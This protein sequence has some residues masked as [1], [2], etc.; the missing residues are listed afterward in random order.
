MTGKYGLVKL[1]RRYGNICLPE[2]IV[3]DVRELRRK[4]LMKTPLSPRLLSEMQA[5]FGRKEQVILFQ[6]RRGY[7]PVLECRQC[8]WVPRCRSC[9]VSLTLHQRE[10]RMVC[11]YCGAS[12]PI[13]RQCPQCGSTD[14]RDMG[15]GTE[16]IEE[17]VT[18]LFPEARVARMDL[19]TTR[20]RSAYER[21]LDDFAHGRTDVL[22]GTQMVT[23]GL[24][25][26]RV[27][28]VGILNADQLL[29]QPDF[30]AYERG[31]Q[32]MA[33]VAGRAGRRGR[34][35]RVVL[36]TR[37]PDLPVIRQVVHNDY[38]GMY[39][40]QM[41]ERHAF[42]YPPFRRLILIY[43]KHRIEN[44]ADAAARMMAGMLRP[45]FGDALL[46][47]DRPA[48]A[49]LQAQYIRTMML[50]LPPNA[51]VTAVREVLWAVREKVRQTAE[52]RS[53]TIYFDVDP[54]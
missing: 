23:K 32:M 24:D 43:V 7:S 19:D 54:L 22:I 18:T 1:T 36:Q 35:G 29:N 20:T 38:R 14:L 39:D 28:V 16:R 44:S 52:G 27:R 25:F 4:K 30:R 15:Y 31:F 42:L 49:R 12:H 2:I 34:Q 47:P 50:K 53:A 33:Q 10:G 45:E 5:A 9:D 8:G 17:V 40:G 6:N 3:E 26:E 41:E 11:H 48:V 21:M 51:S 46:G 13:P 37:Q